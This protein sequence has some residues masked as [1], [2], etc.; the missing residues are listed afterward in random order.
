MNILLAA[1][2]SAGVQALRRLVE[3]GHH[4][5][6]VLTGAVGESR[7]A[8]VAATADTLSVEIL[9]SERVMDPGLSTWIKQKKVDIFLNVHSLY[10]IHEENLRSPSIGSFNLHPGPLPGYAGLNTPSWAIYNGETAHAVT[11]H[12][13]DVGIDTGAIAY[14]AEFEIGETD[15]G[16]SVSARCVREGLPLI[17]RLLEIAVNDPAAIPRR[18]QAGSDRRYFGRDVPQEGLIQW[19]RPARQVVDFVRACDYA[20]FSSPWGEPSASLDSRTV[21]ILRASTTGRASSV[22]PGTIGPP[23]DGGATVA[24]G[25]EWVLVNRVRLDGEVV[26]GEALPEGERLRDGT[27]AT[28]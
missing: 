10:V 26:A 21:S 13:M 5:P 1:E 18:E 28:R 23:T 7:G 6:A 4:V 2:E 24:T 3:A 22:A 16:L 14:S 19:S 8:T 15:T 11:L 27:D 20:P 25:D 9:P 17:T 12:W